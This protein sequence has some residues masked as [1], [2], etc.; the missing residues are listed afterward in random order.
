VE[1]GAVTA[2]DITLLDGAG[3]IVNGRQAQSV[4]GTNGG[5]LRTVG[6][7]TVFTFSI[8]PADTVCA[9]AGRA[10]QMR[11]LELHAVAGGAHLRRPYVFYVRNLWGV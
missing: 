2:M 3:N 10:L 11:R 8:T 6:A 7:A 4:L 5:I 1:L 9:P